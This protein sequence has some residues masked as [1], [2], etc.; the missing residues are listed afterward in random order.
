MIMSAVFTEKMLEEVASKSIGK[1]CS[2][3]GDFAK[4]QAKKIQIDYDGAFKAYLKRAYEKY[5]KIKTLIYKTEPKELYSF[6]VCNSITFDKR[7][8]DA[9]D[10]NNLLDISNFIILQGTGGIGKSTLMKHFFVNT[11]HETDLIPLFIELRD[12][13][14]FDGS[15][16]EFAYNSICRLGFTLEQK[17]FE[18]ALKT[19]CF[20][21][22]LDGYDEV[23]AEKADRAFKEID[24]L[25]D[26]YCNNY[27]LISSRPNQSFIE[28][29]RFSVMDVAPLNKDQALELIR[30]LDFDSEVKERFLVALDENLYERHSSFA[31]NPLLLTIM[32]LTYDNYAEIPQKL[33]IFYD[34]AFETLYSKHDATKAGFR[35]EMKCKLPYD[36]FKYVFSEFC[37]RTYIENQYD[38]SYEQMKEKLQKVMERGETF[39]VENYI[40]DLCN[41]ICVICKD[42]LSYRF[43]HRSFQ[44]YFTAYYLKECSD[45]QQQK[46]CMVLLNR[47]NRVLHDRV[48]DMLQD[49]VPERFEKNIIYSLI[50]KKENEFAS[51]KDR[52]TEFLKWIV[53]R[54]NICRPDEDE[55]MQENEEEIQTRLYIHSGEQRCMLD[56]VRRYRQF[57]TANK[58]LSPR[59]QIIMEQL[60]KGGGEILLEIDEI[61]ANPL[62]FDYI[63]E[64][65]WIGESVEILSGLYVQLTEKYK[66][67]DLD[68]DELLL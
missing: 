52:Y 45:E 42:G 65:T 68:L 44:E 38:F 10:I 50:E 28:F 13:N 12:I 17:Y 22:F 67:Q 43:T 37:F 29:Q 58:P 54:V 66:K 9:T 57:D 39:N 59:E 62:F 15:I 26:L 2:K 3:V 1:M 53:E 41:S 27:F 6:F 18:Y 5:H 51:A 55:E 19:G 48:I 4:D 46:I 60:Q 34:N 25:C 61:L 11:L 63:K 8:V 14:T 30:K 7:I 49:M 31:S 35:R 64:E 16:I 40:W 33:H 20:A 56:E 23:S 21:I 36:T 24:E 32:L 47:G